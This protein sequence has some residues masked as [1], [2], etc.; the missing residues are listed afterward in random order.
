MKNLNISLFIQSNPLLSPKEGA[1]ELLQI[2]LKQGPTKKLK[3]F[4]ADYPYKNIF[5]YCFFE[6]LAFLLEDAKIRQQIA[7]FEII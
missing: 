2:L 1:R 7:Q 5:S 3:I 4:L 6:E